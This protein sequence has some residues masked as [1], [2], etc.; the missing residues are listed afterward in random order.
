MFKIPVSLLLLA[1]VLSWTGCVRTEIEA[2]SRAGFSGE[3]EVAQ[4]TDAQLKL[5]LVGSREKIAAPGQTIS[6]KLTNVGK[7]EVVL[8]DW[9]LDDRE[10]L[11]LECQVWFPG[12]TAPEVD[13]WIPAYEPEKRSARYP[14]TLAPDNSTII[15]IPL[16][17]LQSLVIGPNAERRYF[18][19]AKLNL[20]SVTVSSEIAA[21]T[22]RSRAAGK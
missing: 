8:A 7:K 22:V 20:K 15:E 18:V 14:L 21:F 5:E 17:F 4:I 16:D 2:K 10:N 1:G 11:I 12:T 6:Y 3:E 9:H 13:A 19:R